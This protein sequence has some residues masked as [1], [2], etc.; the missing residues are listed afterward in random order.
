MTKQGPNKAV[1]KLLLTITIRPT[2]PRASVLLLL[3]KSPPRPPFFSPLTA[4]SYRLSLLDFA[5]VVPLALIVCDI[6][7][8]AFVDPHLQTCL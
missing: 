2:L 8:L 4:F 7:V 5:L 6:P 3:C 1:G